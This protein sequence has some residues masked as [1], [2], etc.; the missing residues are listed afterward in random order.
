MQ[1]L[2]LRANKKVDVEK[3]I[4]LEIESDSGTYR[5]IFPTKWGVITI[6]MVEQY[7]SRIN[8]DLS[9]TI[10][11]DMRDEETTVEIIA[12]GGKSGVLLASRGAEKK[13]CKNIADE[14]IKEGF[15]IK[16]N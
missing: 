7:F 16:E 8:S 9:I 1:K 4:P 12:A 3:I 13:A 5:K 10:I 2:L 14:L 15:E 11:S 6:L